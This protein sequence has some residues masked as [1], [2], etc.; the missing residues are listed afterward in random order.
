VSG[1]ITEGGVAMVRVSGIKA[2]RGHLRIRN[3]RVA[4][5]LGGRRVKGRIRSLTEPA[6]AAAARVSA[7]LSR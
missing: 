7:H 6:I 5:A 1:D 4:G 2:A 3:R